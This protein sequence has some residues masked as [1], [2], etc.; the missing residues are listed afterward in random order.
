MSTGPECTDA[1]GFAGSVSGFCRTH[2]LIP[3]DGPIAV[4]FSGGPDSTALLHVL[5]S[6]WPGRVVAVHVDHG[7]TDRAAEMAG[8][9]AVLAERV[10]V[11]FEVV[12]VEV[13][14]DLVRDKG[15]EAAAREV[16]YAA[17]TAAAVR[18]GAAVCALGHTADDRAETLLMNLVRGS[19]LDGL[20]AMR[21]RRGLFVRPLAGSRRAD[22]LAYCAALGLDAVTDPSNAD[23]TLLR[24]RVRFELVP[25][26]ERLRPGALGRIAATA[27]RLESDADYLADAAAEVAAECCSAGHDHVAFDLPVLA[28]MAGPV[29]ARVVRAALVP[30]LDGVAPP[31]AAT[32]AVLGGRAGQL[33]GTP[34]TSRRERDELVVMRPHTGI[35]AVA[36]PPQGAASVSGRRVVVRSCPPGVVLAVRPLAD[37]DRLAGQRRTL[38]DLLARA[39]VKRRQ[40][41]EALTILAD[42]EVAGVAVADHAWVGR[43]GIDVRVLDP[44]DGDRTAR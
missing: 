6:I 8:A 39:G 24:N 21:A 40:R 15:L 2:G 20:A 31:A 10:G 9:A 16:R 30:L 36:L 25:V 37:G 22:T 42:G 19:G 14:A 13:S 32:A 28:A 17:L 5:D 1:A 7:I 41:D 29:A 33:P 43:E 23:T 34:L 11:P 27:A 44:E 35:G 4:A 3:D 26:L 38:R 18:H 12:A